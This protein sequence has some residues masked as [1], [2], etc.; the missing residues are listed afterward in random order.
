MRWIAIA[1]GAAL[2]GVLSGCGGGTSAAVS[3]CEAAVAER[4]PGRTYTFDTQALRDSAR[5]EDDGVVFMSAPLVIDAGMTIEQRQT[6]ECRV[7]GNDII[8]LHFIW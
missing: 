7:R 2:L 4:L 1:S 8:S 6:V 5:S 3:V